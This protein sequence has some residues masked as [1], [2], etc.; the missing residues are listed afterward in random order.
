MKKL[1]FILF[2]LIIGNAFANKDNC[3]KHY[4]QQKYKL[5]LSDCTVSANAGDASSQII[6]GTIYYSGLGGAK[7]NYQEA[8]IWYKKAADQGDDGAENMLGYMY[9]YGNGVKPDYQQSFDWYTKSASQG[10]ANAQYQLD[11]LPHL[12]QYA[13][14][15]Q[16]STT[17]D[18][19]NSSASET[20]SEKVYSTYSDPKN[21]FLVYTI[22]VILTIL[23]TTLVVK[24]I[25]R[26]T[27]IKEDTYLINTHPIGRTCKISAIF[28]IVL[29]LVYPCILILATAGVNNILYFIIGIAIVISFFIAY[30]ILYLNLDKSF[31]TNL[32]RLFWTRI[33]LALFSL[34]FSGIFIMIG[35]LIPET[36]VVA[37]FTVSNIAILLISLIMIISLSVIYY[38][39]G[40]NYK[41]I[42]KNTNNELFKYSGKCMQ[43]G[44]FLLPILIGGILI[45]IA[46]IIILIGCLC[47]AQKSA[48][49]SN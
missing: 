21:L 17:D 42:G 10:N 41:K 30:S 46:E 14:D 44:T 37:K 26:I 32:N 3:Y 22:T 24:I 11:N 47:K 35:K 8:M 13:A 15:T 45:G 43:V 2:L 18:S 16:A 48:T 25:N 20:L 34:L 49:T 12:K 1:I 38:K 40:L 39:T 9:Y 31:N 29:S 6:L 7:Q 27:R 33:G 28:I 36:N 5:A 23:I 19:G 4:S